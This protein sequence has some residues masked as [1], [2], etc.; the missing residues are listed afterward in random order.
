MTRKRIIKCHH[1]C[2]EDPNNRSS[3]PCGGNVSNCKHYL[4]YYC[5]KN[6]HRYGSSTCRCLCNSCAELPTLE[7]SSPSQVISSEL[8]TI[9]I[10]QLYLK[11]PYCVNHSFL[12]S[13]VRKILTL[14]YLRRI[15]VLLS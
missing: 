8:P 13:V 9:F 15:F 11:F 3:Y 14:C 1:N 5:W 10:G 12:Y 6:N 7:S 4:W 2:I